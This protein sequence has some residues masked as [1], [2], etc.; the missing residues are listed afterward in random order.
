ME[1]LGDHKKNY[2]DIFNVDESNISKIFRGFNKKE[3]REICLKVIDKKQIEL[4]DYDFILEQIKREE[5][6]TKLCKSENIINFY[7]KLETQ[8][9]IIFELEYYSQNIMEYISNNG[10]LRREPENFKNIIL[11]LANALLIIHTKGVMHRDIKTNNIF[12][13]NENDLSLIK[14]GDFG[15]STYIKENTS[16]PIGTIIYCAPEIINNLK[17][18]EKCDLWSLGITLYELYFGFL[19]Y[20]YNVTINTIMKA[21][22]NP[23]KNFNYKKTNIHQLDYLFKKLLTIKPE[24]RM[25]Y[26][27]FFDYVFND[28]FM[29][30]MEEIKKIIKEQ[31]AREDPNENK[32]DESFYENKNR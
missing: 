10:E 6:I 13:V 17:Y 22:Y 27:E 1:F 16:D 24:N 18:D 28:N 32:S 21:I 15:C 8:N 31:I 23:E 2:E 26:E 20:G 19:P 3:G 9:S 30:N 14:L 11:S 12:L 5:E 29:N 4:G 7:Q 25:T